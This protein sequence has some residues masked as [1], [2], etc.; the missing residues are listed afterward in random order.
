MMLLKAFSVVGNWKVNP[1]SMAFCGLIFLFVKRSSC[2]SPSI[3]FITN[4]GILGK[5]KGFWSFS[6]RAFVS[7]WFEIGLGE[8]ALYVPS[9]WFFTAKKYIAARSWMW[10]HDVICLPFPKAAPNPKRM[11]LIISWRAPPFLANT[12]PVLILQT[13]MSSCLNLL[14]LSSHFTTTLERKLSCVAM[15]SSL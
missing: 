6:A 12:I 14:T 7:S 5:N 15:E 4:L 2:I 3:H 8:T 11:G 10:I 13:L 1:A 9:H